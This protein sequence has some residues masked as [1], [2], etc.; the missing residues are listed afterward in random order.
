MCRSRINKVLSATK[1]IVLT[2]YRVQLQEIKRAVNDSRYI[3]LY[4]PYERVWRNAYAH[5][6]MLELEPVQPEPVHRLPD[7]RRPI[8]GS[9]VLC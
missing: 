1:T 7:A 8:C 9:R 4:S 2:T 3:I 5:Y 6:R